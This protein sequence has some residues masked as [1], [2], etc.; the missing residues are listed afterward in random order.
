M[1]AFSAA[2]EQARLDALARY[3]ILDTASET[4]FDR[5]TSLVCRIL[6]VP[7]ATVTFLDAHRQLAAEDSGKRSTD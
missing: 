4:V 1:T 6:A 5:I 7:M 3:D 2:S